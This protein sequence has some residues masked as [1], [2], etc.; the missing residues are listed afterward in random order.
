MRFLGDHQRNAQR[1]LVDRKAVSDFPGAPIWLD[2]T[3][4]STDARAIVPRGLLDGGLQD[5][6]DANA[7]VRSVA[8]W[9]AFPP[10]VL[11]SA[12]MAGSNGDEDDERNQSER[13]RLRFVLR[14]VQLLACSACNGTLDAMTAPKDVLGGKDQP[15]RSSSR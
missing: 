7:T 1:G 12:S 11:R 15:R 10:S 13:S 4:N 5:A 6:I 9:D 8:R 14:T 2:R 3:I